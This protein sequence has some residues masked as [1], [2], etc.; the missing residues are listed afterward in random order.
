MLMLMIMTDN[1]VEPL[2]PSV[3]SAQGEVMP[4]KHISP[5][6]SCFIADMTMAEENWMVNDNYLFKIYKWEICVLM[7]TLT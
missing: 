2:K 5:N 6:T 1:T 7:Y 3:Q 4:N